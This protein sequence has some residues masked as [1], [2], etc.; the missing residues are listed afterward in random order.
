MRDPQAKA[1]KPMK[2]NVYERITAQIV[3]ELEKGIRPWLK[4]WNVE[5]AFGRIVRPNRVNGAAYR[6]INV[7]MLWAAA[8]E[9]G[10]SSPTWMTFKQASERGGKVRKGEKGSLVVYASTVTRNEVDPYTGEQQQR[11]IPFMK[12]F[13]VFNAEQVEGLPTHL[14]AQT[15]PVVDPV[16]RIKRAETFFA[17]TGAKISNGGNRAYFS[18]LEDRIQMPPFE[19]FMEP[20]AY[21][22]TLAHEMT[23]WTKTA[24]RLDR[25]FGRKRFG[26]SGCAMEELVAELGAAFLCADLGLSPEPREEHA[27]Y[28]GH[29]LKVLKADKRAIFSAAAHAQRAADFLEGFQPKE[30]ATADGM[31][32]AKQ[33]QV[34]T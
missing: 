6:G 10:Y 33:G 18:P 21:Y 4:P 2:A 8:A 27:A 22:A 3:S 26:D 1:E 34:A 25:D 24:A 5:H 32:G 16:R 20:E 17:S 29:W 23:H 14:Y 12:G 15:E 30:V 7:F 9:R 13:M 11:D 19:A 31:E 28:L